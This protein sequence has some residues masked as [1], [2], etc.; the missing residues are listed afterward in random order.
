MN[1][2]L[3]QLQYLRLDSLRYENCHFQ[4]QFNQNK[5][6]ELKPI[7]REHS[8]RRTPFFNNSQLVLRTVD[9]KY[10]PKPFVD[11][12]RDPYKYRK[13]QGNPYIG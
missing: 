7:S 8:I 3:D 1:K 12:K 4:P 9:E 11:N 2:Y 5:D 6:D 13:L 10:V